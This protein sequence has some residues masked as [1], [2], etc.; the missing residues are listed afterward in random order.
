MGYVAPS[1]ALDVSNSNTPEVADPTNP[2]GVSAFRGERFV[3]VRSAGAG[4]ALRGVSFT[5]RG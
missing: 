4:E 1:G 3:T 5:P 2:V